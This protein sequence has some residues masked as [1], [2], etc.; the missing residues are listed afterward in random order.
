MKPMRHHSIVEV[1]STTDASVVF[2]VVK[3]SVGRRIDLMQ[4]IRELSG[5]Y[6]FLAAGGATAE[7]IDAAL[8]RQQIDCTYLRWGLVDVDGL[9]IDG[10]AADPETLI[11]RGPEDL[12]REA[13]DAIKRECHLTGEERKN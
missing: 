6:E 9:E 3:M 1:R 10:I 7:Q 5:K 12:C 4:R 11:T 2:R 13:V 8:V